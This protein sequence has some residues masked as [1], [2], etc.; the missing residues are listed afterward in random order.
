MNEGDI[1]SFKRRG[2]AVRKAEKKEE[3]N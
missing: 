1:I 2:I 3:K